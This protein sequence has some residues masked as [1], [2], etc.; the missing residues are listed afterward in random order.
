[1]AANTCVVVVTHLSR[2]LPPLPRTLGLARSVSPP[3]VAVRVYNSRRVLY[4]AR[5]VYIRGGIAA[6]LAAATC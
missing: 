3:E 4:I 2:L 5:T 1:M 6:Q